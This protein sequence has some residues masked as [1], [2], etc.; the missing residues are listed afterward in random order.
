MISRRFPNCDVFRRKDSISNNC[1]LSTLTLVPDVDSSVHSE[2]KW[3]LGWTL[4]PLLQRPYYERSAL[5]PCPFQGPTVKCLICSPLC[6]GFVVLALMLLILLPFF[7]Y[8]FSTENVILARRAFLGQRMRLRSWWKF[9]LHYIKI[10]VM[11]IAFLCENDCWLGSG[12]N[13]LRVNVISGSFWSTKKEEKN[14][15]LSF[16]LRL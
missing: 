3:A 2:K 11:V 13:I 12:N 6:A 15:V 9:G 4:S 14:L 1:L 16:Q 7:P 5:G 8:T 10:L